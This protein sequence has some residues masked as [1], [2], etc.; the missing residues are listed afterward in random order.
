MISRACGNPVVNAL[1]TGSFCMLLLLSD[2][3][4]QNQLFQTK[5]FRNTIRV[6]IL[7]S[8]DV[9]AGLIWVQTSRQRY[10]L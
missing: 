5:I 6:W 9:L 3:F 2:N 4:F 1:P 8:P 7:I 10:D